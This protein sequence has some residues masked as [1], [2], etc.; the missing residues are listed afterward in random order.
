MGEVNDIFMRI[1]IFLIL[2][3][4]YIYFTYNYI[5]DINDIA[6]KSRR[7]VGGDNEN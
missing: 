1:S 3:F 5:N 2:S 6:E 4:I 7:K